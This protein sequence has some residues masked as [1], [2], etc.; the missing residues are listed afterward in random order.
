[1]ALVIAF[2]GVLSILPAKNPSIYVE[3]NNGC[4]LPRR[5]FC[6]ETPYVGKSNPYQQQT[7]WE[8]RQIIKN[9]NLL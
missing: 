6:S 9:H 3:I 7:F 2:G 8:N 1:M 5:S 4:L